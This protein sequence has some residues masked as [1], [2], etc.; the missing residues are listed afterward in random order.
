[1]NP[2][3]PT[4]TD[5]MWRSLI[6][7]A[8]VLQVTAAD[9]YGAIKRAAAAVLPAP[10]FSAAHVRNFVAELLAR[11][12]LG[13]TTVWNGI[14]VPHAVCEHAREEPRVAWLRLD[15]PLPFDDDISALADTKVSLVVPVACTGNP[16]IDVIALSAIFAV[17]ADQVIARRLL[18]SAEPLLFKS[19][20][21]ERLADVLKQSAPKISKEEEWDAS[22]TI[23]VVNRLG[24]HARP[25][26]ML[27]DVAGQFVS[28]MELY[29]RGQSYN[30][31]SIMEVMLMAARKD[32]LVTVT[33]RGTDA[34]RAV[35]TIVS[36][37][38]S[39]FEELM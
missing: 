12:R 1:M 31:K 16:D 39:G 28:D 30:A 34:A 2:N 24:I 4:L 22:H 37:I 10:K 35:N 20:V 38:Q 15:T 17:V 27:C 33:A 8:P 3:D 21:C 14:A 6:E 7:S 29:T 36:L 5:Q 13:T 32:Q 25:S 11:E 19:A 9:K 26:M 18:A 23:V